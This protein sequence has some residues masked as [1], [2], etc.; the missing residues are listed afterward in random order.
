MLLGRFIFD[1]ANQHGIKFGKDYFIKPGGGN[2]LSGLNQVN[3]FVGANNSG[4]S[5]ILRAVYSQDDLMLPAFVD[6]LEEFIREFEVLFNSSR[7]AQG[8]IKEAV[9]F[10]QDKKVLSQKEFWSLSKKVAGN[11]FTDNASVVQRLNKMVQITKEQIESNPRVWSSNREPDF[12]AKM[13]E[14]LEKYDDF[15]IS[16]NNL[17]SYYR[18]YNPILRGMRTIGDTKS[19]LLRDRTIKDYFNTITDKED[20]RVFTGQE[21]FEDLKDKLLGNQ[22]DRDFV[23]RFQKFLSENFFN[24]QEVTL[25]PSKNSDVVAVTFNRNIDTE[26]PVYLFGDG[27][28]SIICVT[29]PLFSWL[30]EHDENSNNGLILCVE[31]P[32]IYLH[33]SMQRKLVEVLMDK[34]FSKVQYFIT[35]HSNHFLDLLYEVEYSNRISVFSVSQ[36]K[37]GVK[38]IE[39]QEDLTGVVY[40]LLGVQPSSILLANKTMWVEGITDRMY[41]KHGLKLYFESNPKEEVPN[42]DL[43][44]A[45]IEY[46]GSNLD[47]YLSR[48]NNININAISNTRNVFLLV[49]QDDTGDD[50]SAKSKRYGEIKELVEKN[51]GHFALTDGREI[52]NYIKPEILQDIFKKVEIGDHVD[53]LNENLPKYL[54]KQ[55]A[56]QYISSEGAFNNKKNF[57]MKV[58]E[59]QKNW[60]D[61]SESMQNLIR[62]IVVFVSKESKED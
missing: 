14:L 40:D 19:T 29:Y 52:E 16:L 36:D 42:E 4:K 59:R 45:F 6:K 43:D 32:E 51:G 21:I 2:N 58:I 1:P 53:Y 7:I 46:S 41:I 54:K 27:L 48:D 60:D 47:H 9:K 10:L 61:L 56:T 38:I 31:E 25:T 12:V 34:K 57:A 62:A 44:Y 23:Q 37:K 15:L 26:R 50:D 49:D 28:Q 35:T 55:G 39:K 3:I 24:K 30:Q 18:V 5:R 33:P 22:N 20:R 17:P 13:K 8:Q 11:S